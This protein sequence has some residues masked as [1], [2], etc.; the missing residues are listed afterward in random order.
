[1]VAPALAARPAHPARRGNPSA[2]APRKRWEGDFE[3]ATG[4]A[5]GVVP[6]IAGGIFARGRVRPP[7]LPVAL[8]LE[9]AYFPRK[10]VDAE[11]G[12]G[13]YFALFNVGAA[14]CT[15][16][17]RSARVHV[18]GCAG[19]DIAATT[20]EG[21]GYDDTPRFWSFTF[22]L[23]A[24]VRVGF[25]A[26]RGLAVVLGPDLMVPFGRDEFVTVTPEEG[27]T[28]LWQMKAAGFGFELGG[29]WEL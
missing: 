10:A 13:A 26:S 1:V 16:S 27:T 29:V 8:E 4:V 19:P 14:V 18:F 22:A 25:R 20:G 28:T 21:Y 23:S 24:R 11:P 5:T 2:V 3:L 9:S 6:E 17:D 15:K 7:S 12:R